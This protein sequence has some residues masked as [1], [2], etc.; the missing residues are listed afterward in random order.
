MLSPPWRGS[1]GTYEPQCLEFY[2]TERSI[3]TASSEQVRRPI[4]KEGLEQ[5]RN[6]EPW[7]GPSKDALGP[8]AT[9]ARR[10]AGSQIDCGSILRN[11]AATEIRRLW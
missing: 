6:F 7:L 11:A 10:S 5:W 3:R 1:R 2:K 9:S 4:F 8:L